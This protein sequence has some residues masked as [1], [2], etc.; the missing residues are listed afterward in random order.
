MNERDLAKIKINE[1]SRERDGSLE[2]PLE[3]SKMS[4]QE[5]ADF[6][7]QSSPE[8]KDIVARLELV[9]VMYLNK[10]GKFCNGQVYVDKD[11]SPEIKEFFQFLLDQQFKLDKVIPIQA[12]QYSGS[13][14]ASMLDNNSSAA[15]YRVIS[16]T[17][18]LSLHAYGFALD[19]NPA[20]NPVQKDGVSLPPQQDA[21]RNLDDS[22]TFTAEHPVVKWLEARGWEWGGHWQEPYQDYHH[23]QKPLATKEYVKQLQLQLQEGEITKEQFDKRLAKAEF[24]STL[25][26]DANEKI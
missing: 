10:E 21:V 22:Q 15:N 14:D 26:K 9:D 17:N 24:N 5:V 18:R 19:L 2:V 11:L 8:A 20:D 13:D 1:L 4:E 7:L 25:L 3:I 23:F 12:K 6:I 16:G